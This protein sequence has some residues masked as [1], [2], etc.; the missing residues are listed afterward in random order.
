MARCI[1]RRV[2]KPDD[3]HTEHEFTTY[4]K[5]LGL[6]NQLTLDFTPRTDDDGWTPR[7]QAQAHRS[8]I[9][10]VRRW[11]SPNREHQQAAT[12]YAIHPFLD[13][14]LRTK[15]RQRQ[16]TPSPHALQT[17]IVPSQGTV[18][19]AVERPDNLTPSD[20]L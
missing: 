8:S 6:P 11:L 10:M 9:T 4:S 14:L 12:R 15:L 13:D 2:S 19:R 3:M 18:Q 16:S 7:Q 17:P 5:C 1:C 20:V